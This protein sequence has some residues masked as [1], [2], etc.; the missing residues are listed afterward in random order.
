MV[1]PV[2]NYLCFPICTEEKFFLLYLVS[3]QKHFMY[4][5]TQTHAHSYTHRLVHRPELLSTGLREP[6]ERRV[7]LLKG[8]RR[9]SVDNVR[10]KNGKIAWVSKWKDIWVSFKFFQ[11]DVESQ[12]HQIGDFCEVRVMIFKIP[13]RSCARNMVVK[14][15]ANLTG[16]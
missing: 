3:P 14:S 10:R 9:H 11:V 7:G 4:V 5:H 8:A 6:G 12:Y 16:L 1:K 2:I 13:L 15:M